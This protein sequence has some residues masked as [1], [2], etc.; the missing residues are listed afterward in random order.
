MFSTSDSSDWPEADREQ[1]LRTLRYWRTRQ[2]TAQPVSPPGDD[3][4]AFGSRVRFVLHGQ[5]KQIDIVGDD[6]GSSSVQG[7]PY[8][9]PVN[10]FL[11]WPKEVRQHGDR[12]SAWPSIREGNED[13]LVAVQRIT[14]PAAMFTDE[15]AVSE[16]R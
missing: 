9:P 12:H 16:L 3:E 1:H 13:N 7:Y 10:R 11:I 2:A 4:I 15:R 14:I 6:E 5:T 8:W